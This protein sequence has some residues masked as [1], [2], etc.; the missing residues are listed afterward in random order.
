MK[1]ALICVFIAF[2]TIAVHALD[3]AKLESHHKKLK[4]K[5]C[6]PDNIV[7]GENLDLCV[8]CHEKF[9]PKNVST[10]CQNW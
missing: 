4:E 8:A 9:V 1:T 7:A 2:G 10:N 6:D 5:L 3:Q